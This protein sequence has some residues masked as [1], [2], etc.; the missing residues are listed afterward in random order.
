MNSAMTR[1][2]RPSG[3]ASCSVLSSPVIVATPGAPT[4]TNSA[5]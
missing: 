3:T 4:S 1:P 5:M 2:R